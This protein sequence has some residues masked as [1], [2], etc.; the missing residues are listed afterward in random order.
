MQ[1]AHHLLPYRYISCVSTADRIAAALPMA[2]ELW[3]P[4][5]LPQLEAGSAVATVELPHHLACSTSST[6]WP[7]WSTISG[8]RHP[9]SDDAT[10]SPAAT[11]GAE[12]RPP[13]RRTTDQ[14]GLLRGTGCHDARSVGAQRICART[15]ATAVGRIGHTLAARS[16]VSD[17]TTCF[18]SPFVL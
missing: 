6:L 10:D 13:N 16:L 3:C 7:Q 1:S 11:G 14:A 15:N 4:S 17:P 18:G 12:P 9:G 8:H 5:G 2:G